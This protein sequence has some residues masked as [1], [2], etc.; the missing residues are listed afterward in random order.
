MGV[1]WDGEVFV[2]TYVATHDW[3]PGHKAVSTQEALLNSH[4][5]IP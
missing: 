4:V 1:G 5:A 2:T 3:F